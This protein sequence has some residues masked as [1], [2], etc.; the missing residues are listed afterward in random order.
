MN[1][2]KGR[3][4]LFPCVLFECAFSNIRLLY[5]QQDHRLSK[6]FNSLLFLVFAPIIMF[7]VPLLPMDSLQVC[8]IRFLLTIDS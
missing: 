8:G 2:A 5:Y 4:V 7:R 1:R 3:R 6:L